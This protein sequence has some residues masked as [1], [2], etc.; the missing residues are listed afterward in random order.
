ME[1][2][3]TESNETKHRTYSQM[4]YLARDATLAEMRSASSRQAPSYLTVTTM[5][6]TIYNHCHSSIPATGLRML[7]CQI[8]L[9]SQLRS[10]GTEDSGL[11]TVCAESCQVNL[12]PSMCWMIRLSH[13]H[14]G[15]MTRKY[16][17]DSRFEVI[18][19]DSRTSRFPKGCLGGRIL[20]HG[21]FA[22]ARKLTSFYNTS[23]H[24]A[25]LLHFLIDPESV[26]CVRHASQRRGGTAGQRRISPTRKLAWS[27]SM[28]N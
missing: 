23:Q 6:G 20:P 16:I 13:R 14:A 3:V 8:K 21:S 5:A 4:A 27:M 15:L 28:Q 11:P 9:D 25:R 17:I 26:R 19:S 22:R 7:R 2:G 10:I 1:D 12:G 24:P 18:R